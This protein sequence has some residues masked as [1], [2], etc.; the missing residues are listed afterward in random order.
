[1][2]FF[3]ISSEWELNSCTRDELW[4]SNVYMGKPWKHLAP[5]PAQSENVDLLKV[6]ILEY[7]LQDMQIMDRLGTTTHFIIQVLYLFLNNTDLK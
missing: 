3:I 7:I 6:N 5:R 1:M 4:C 2:F